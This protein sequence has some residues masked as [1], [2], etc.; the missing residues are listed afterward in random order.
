LRATYLTG[1]RVYLRGMTLA[2]KD[3]ATAWFDGPFPIDATR[4]EEFLKDEHKDLS[5]RERHLIIGLTDTDEIAGCL[6]IYTNGQT[7]DIW[8]SM[9]PWLDDADSLQADTLRMV[10]PWLRDEA[11]MITTDLEVPADESRTIAAAE[12]LG[13]QLAV[14]LREHIARPG[15]RVDLLLYQA[16]GPAWTYAEEAVNA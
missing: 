10:I 16:P 9:A 2:D 13:M 8:F 6:H 4:A 3:H 11:T 7:A 1:E 12:E 14:R 5:S 15:H